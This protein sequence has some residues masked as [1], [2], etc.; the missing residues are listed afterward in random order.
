MQGKHDSKWAYLI[1]TGIALS[2]VHNVWLTSLTTNAKGETWF[3]LPQLGYL[4][5]I[6]GSAFFLL[7]N[8]DRV[9]EAG[10]GDRRTVA[11]ILLI[12]LAISLSGVAYK[13]AARIAPLG[14]GLAWITL[15][16]SSRVLGTG[17]MLPLGIGATIASVG[18]VSHAV[19]HPGQITGGYIFENNYDIVVGY[20][21]LGASLYSGRWRI[22]L[23]ALSVTAVA[24]TGS[25][26]G[27]LALF[28]VGVVVFIR[29]DWGKPLFSILC[30][31]TVTLAVWFGLGWG[32]QL[33]S[34]A[35]D[36]VA[37]RSS[38][39]RAV[40]TPVEEIET[41]ET[42]TIMTDEDSEQRE[43]QGTVEERPVSRFSTLGYRYS[44]LRAAMYNLKPLGDGY[45]ITVFREG[46]VHN[47]PMIIVQQLGWPGAVAGLCW[48]VIGVVGW[49]NRSW[50]Y[51]W[52]LMLALSVL[53]HFTWTQMAPYWWVLVGVSS[54]AMEDTDLLCRRGKREAAPAREEP[55]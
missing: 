29:K 55:A 47:V 11:G 39:E 12:A 21:L 46:I 49:R 51:S 17:L 13:G 9:K 16:L 23:I 38:M 53:D 3:F 25:P 36:V 35:F 50:R 5:L 31:L 4:L 30:V 26:E 27:V 42:E 45:N 18:V 32:Q 52:T 20:I 28:A 43:E 2:P 1:G 40:L 54:L 7:R 33:Y 14:L 41:T 15:Y 24:L 8:W 19:I 22:P 44:V 34:Y 10:W 48:L 37:G 6:L